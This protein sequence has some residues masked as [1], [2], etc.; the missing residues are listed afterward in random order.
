[1]PS[2]YSSSTPGATLTAPQVEAVLIE[3][4]KAA[5]VVLQAGPQVFYSR[6]GVPLRI[7][8]IDAITATDPWR[9][10]NTQIAETD[11]TLGEVVLLPSTL[12]SLKVLH[13]ISNEL[14]RHAVT[15]IATTLGSALV[16][17]VARAADAAFLVGDGAVNTIRG[18]A[19]A[20]GVQT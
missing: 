2:G 10:E 18:L 16:A 3:P 7:P 1:M 14:A 8:R 11:P 6:G 12:K 5:A 17:E 13:R 15:D 9:S 19:N 20:T 4:L